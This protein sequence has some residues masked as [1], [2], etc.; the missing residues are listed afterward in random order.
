MVEPSRIVMQPDNGDVRR[1]DWMAYLVLP[2][3]HDVKRFLR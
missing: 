1:L 3:F 2:R